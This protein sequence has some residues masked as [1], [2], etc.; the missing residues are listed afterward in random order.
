ME[1][2]Q[3]W[4]QFK[5]GIGNKVKFWHDTWCDATPL[6]QAFPDLYSIV[7]LKNGLVNDHI[8]GGENHVSWDLHLRQ[9][10]NNWEILSISRILLRLERAGISM[11]S[12]ED[13][14]IWTP[15]EDQGFSVQ[16]FYDIIR[17]RANYSKLPSTMWKSKMPEKKCFLL[18]LLHFNKALTLDNLQKT[19]FSFTNRCVMCGCMEESASHMFIHCPIPRSI[20][21]DVLHSFHLSWAMLESL[22]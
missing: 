1:E 5:V 20:W 7:I 16:S 6:A 10:T 2:F 21:S 15:N 3:L 4:T 12:D 11:G 17:Q 18:W 19:G 8:I 9:E 14:R 13:K 22:P